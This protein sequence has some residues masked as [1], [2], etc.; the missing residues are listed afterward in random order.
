MEAP[1]PQG[2]FTLEHTNGAASDL[3]WSAP[4]GHVFCRW[5]AEPERGDYLWIRL[6]QT[7]EQDGDAGPRLDIDVC[8]LSQRPSGR[9]EPMPAGAHGSHC[10]PDPGFAIWWHEGD[11]AFNNGAGPAD[12]SCALEIQFDAASMTLTGEFACADLASA[13]HAETTEPKL[14][15]LG[16]VS[17]LAG[18]FRCD[19]Q[20]MPP[21]P[22]S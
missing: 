22:S 21:R 5:Y 18:R 3:S 12:P 7:P 8:R 20:R 4:E 19:V 9:Y 6:A 13:P 11:D 16:P 1:G 2:A 14:Q 15:A 10:S 17:V